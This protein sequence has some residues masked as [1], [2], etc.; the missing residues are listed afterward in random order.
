MVLACAAPNRSAATALDLHPSGQVLVVG[1]MLKQAYGAEIHL[2]DVDSGLRRLVHTEQ[3][4]GRQTFVHSVLFDAAGDGLVYALNE[5]TRHLD[6]ETGATRVLAGY[7]Q[8]RTSDFNPFCLRPG[9][10]AAR[11]RL[12]VF[13]AGDR[14]RVLDMV[15]GDV[16]HEVV[17]KDRGECR[18][19]ALSRSGRLLALR[20]GPYGCGVAGVQIEIWDVD[21]GTLTRTL[22]GP[23]PAGVKDIGFDPQERWVVANGEYVEGPFAIDIATDTLAWAAPAPTA[24]APP[25]TAPPATIPTGDPGHRRTCYAWDYAPDGATLAI[26]GRGEIVLL[27]AQTRAPAAIQPS[28]LGTGRTGR[29]VYSADGRLVAAGGDSGRITVCAV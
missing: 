1:T 29:V 5:E 9:W 7:Q 18:A 19:G 11:R 16:L 23:F 15:S 22:R 6:L 21:T 13:E 20:F 28:W 14:V 17:A 12:L 10:D 4:H 2:I 26:G 27:D 8:W 3:S 25:A 24:P